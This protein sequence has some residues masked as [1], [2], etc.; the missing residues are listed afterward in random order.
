MIRDP[1]K[2]VIVLGNP[3]S[4][5]TL[6]RLILTSHPAVC[7]PPEG[8]FMCW[9]WPAFSGWTSGDWSKDE[10]RRKFAHAVA[11]SKKF[12]TWRISE[13]EVRDA[14]SD[15]FPE[16]YRQACIA[17]YDLYARKNKNG[18]TIWGDK[19]NFYTS[20]TELLATLFPKGLFIHLVRDPRD[21]FCSY[22]DMAVLETSSAYKP[23]LSSDASTVAAEWVKNNRDVTDILTAKSEISGYVIRY[24][25]LVEAPEIEISKLCAWMGLEYHPDML[26][27]HEQNKEKTLE[28]P[29]TMDWKRKTLQKI[30]AGQCERFR[31]ELRED[32]IA[33]IEKVAG[34]SM[35]QFGYLT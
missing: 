11:G 1:E 10:N 31:R 33:S 19:N 16:T 25:D 20:Q 22:R 2:P 14:L 18:A 32:E 5:T 27:F 21:V 17:I 6:L 29:E 35:R 12:E 34:E 30:S 9:L 13:T 3:R 23:V 15:V 7:I 26:Q 28:P 24:E 4:G 8:G